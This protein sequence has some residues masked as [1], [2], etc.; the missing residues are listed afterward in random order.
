MK[1]WSTTAIRLPL[2]AS[3][4][5]ALG[6]GTGMPPVLLAA[7]GLLPLQKDSAQRVMPGKNYSA[8]RY[9]ELDQINAMNVKNLKEAWSFST[10]IPRGH[11]VRREHFHMIVAPVRASNALGNWTNYCLAYGADEADTRLK[12][13]HHG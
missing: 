13:P 6:M 9:S 5:L 10:G 7:D 8:W 4:A 2:G 3:M 11:E 1:T 12:E